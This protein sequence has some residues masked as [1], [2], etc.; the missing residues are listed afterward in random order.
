MLLVTYHIYNS[1]GELGSLVAK[2]S[3]SKWR[4]ILLK[5]H[6]GVGVEFSESVGIPHD[7]EF[8]DL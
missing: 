4:R 1:L 3:A 2:A 7:P 8:L 5:S 6:G